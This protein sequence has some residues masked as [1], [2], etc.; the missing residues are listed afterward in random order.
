IAELAAQGVEV[1]AEKPIYL[2]LPTWMAAEEYVN[3]GNAYKQS[4][5]S[6]LGGKVV[7][8]LTECATQDEWQ[9][10]GY[11]TNSG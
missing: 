7:I 3:Q 5:E 4:V 8:V 1:S 6:V 10:S 9:Y 2:E 11:Y